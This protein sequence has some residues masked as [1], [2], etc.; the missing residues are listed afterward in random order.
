MEADLRK[1]LNTAFFLLKVVVVF[2]VSHVASISNRPGCGAIMSDYMFVPFFIF[3]YSVYV[4]AVW[5]AMEVLD[6][7]IFLKFNKISEKPK[8]SI[9]IIVCI[10]PIMTFPT[11]W[12]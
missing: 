1:N 10:L 2:C 3:G 4:I 12:C 9:D 6:R 7:Y 11:M 8:I 5:L